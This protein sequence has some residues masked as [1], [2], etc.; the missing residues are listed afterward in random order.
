MGQKTNDPLNQP[1]RLASVPID[2]YIFNICAEHFGMNFHTN[3]KR[4]HM[5]QWRIPLVAYL[6]N[7]N[8]FR[9]I[10]LKKLDVNFDLLEIEETARILQVD[11]DNDVEN[12]THQI[13][14][15]QINK[16][17]KDSDDDDSS[18]SDESTTSDDECTDG[19]DEYSESDDVKTKN[20][21]PVDKKCTENNNVEACEKN[22]SDISDKANAENN[23][24]CEL[25]QGISSK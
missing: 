3:C 12:V 10:N 24:K 15:C 17:S 8:L 23:D 13:A 14:Q 21:I 16:H 5:V 19:D 25:K 11:D 6:I 1:V 22:N 9:Q 4:W 2:E 20:D 18:S 7:L